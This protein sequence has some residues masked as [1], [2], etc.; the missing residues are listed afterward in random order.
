MSDAHLDDEAFSG[1]LDGGG[2]A[3][4]DAAHLAVCP[5]CRAR[6]AALRA[7]VEAL[8]TPP[9]PPPQAV[10]E[11][12]LAAA[13]AVA[14]P[15]RP[16]A[17]VAAAA[18]AAVAAAA[19]AVVVPL[20]R[21]DHPDRPTAAP[22]AVTQAPAIKAPAIDLG[23]LDEASLAAAVTAALAAREHP[24]ATAAPRPTPPEVGA[25]SAEHPATAGAPNVAGSTTCEDALRASSP[26]L[27][28]L[29]LAA[30]AT[31]HGRPASVLVFR[32]ADGL[33][34]VYVTDPATC[35]IRHFASLRST[36]R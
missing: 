19:A 5:A 33:L 12:H 28:P 22:E 23:A 21:S 20:V 11:R 2:D 13:L 8:A 10:R 15:R 1:L 36:N 29:V 17:L 31:W 34:A 25:A 32:A 26:D 14:R 16:R 30:T 9:P 3:V 24:D 18:A 35:E 27:P 4:H 6:L 7:A